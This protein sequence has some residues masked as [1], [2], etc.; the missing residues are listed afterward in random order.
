MFSLVLLLAAL[1]L[2]LAAGH[3][4]G[5]IHNFVTFG[6]SYSDSPNTAHS[7]VPWPAYLAGYTNT[8]LYPFA[9]SGATC[10]NLIT[11]RP[12]ASI[13]ETQLPGYFDSDLGLSPQDTLYIQ[14]IGTNDL[15]VHSLITGSNGASIVDVTE[16]MVNWVQVL[17]DS[18]ARNFLLLNV[19]N[20]RWI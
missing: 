14:W 4:P 16:C 8:S 15:G 7:G 13:C 12:S 17:Y 10:S 11:P 5:Q 9:R 3:R 19:R 1:P 20:I 18:G 2:C 6:D